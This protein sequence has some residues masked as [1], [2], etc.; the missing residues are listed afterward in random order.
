MR[1]KSRFRSVCCV[2][3]QN[4]DDASWA[5]KQRDSSLG[6]NTGEMFVSNFPVTVS[7]LLVILAANP[8]TVDRRA[9]AEYLM[10]YSWLALY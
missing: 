6:V 4:L 1:G 7:F 5:I 8:G 2:V 10:V 9:W 3:A